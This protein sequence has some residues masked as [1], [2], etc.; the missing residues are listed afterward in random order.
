MSS[1][2]EPM[3]HTILYGVV[4]PW[5]DLVC[6]TNNG[7]TVDGRPFHIASSIQKEMDA[8]ISSLKPHSSYGRPFK[9]LARYGKIVVAVRWTL[10]M[11]AAI[12]KSVHRLCVVCLG[13]EF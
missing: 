1:F 6:D 5:L 10:S 12:E 8:V 13:L 11:L 3:S 9:L 7:I 4:K 2:L